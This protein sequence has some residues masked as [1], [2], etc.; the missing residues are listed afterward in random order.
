MELDQSCVQDRIF[1]SNLKPFWKR[2][3]TKNV[4]YVSNLLVSVSKFGID[5]TKNHW[6]R[7]VSVSHRFE[8]AGIVHPY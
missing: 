1:H 7:I 8:K 2:C 5:T 3:V 4:L 6:Y